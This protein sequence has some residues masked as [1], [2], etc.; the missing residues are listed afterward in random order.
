MLRLSHRVP[1]LDAIDLRC[2]SF[3][4]KVGILARFVTGAG[5]VGEDVRIHLRAQDPGSHVR[6]RLGTLHLPPG[7]AQTGIERSGHRRILCCGGRLASLRPREQFDPGPV[8]PAQRRD[9]RL[10]AT[11]CEIGA[12]LVAACD[13]RVA[14]AVLVPISPVEDLQCVLQLAE[15]RRIRRQQLLDQPY[16]GAG[17]RGLSILSRRLDFRGQNHRQLV[18]NIG[19]LHLRE[20]I[21]DRHGS[22]HGSTHQ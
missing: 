18:G 6:A 12:G 8:G 14:V 4:T 20:T 19:R 9:G 15:G 10:G 17:V 13:W 11:R 22:G 16:D 7:I 3:P 21:G 1:A 5:P 2:C